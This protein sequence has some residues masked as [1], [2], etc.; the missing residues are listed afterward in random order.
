MAERKLWPALTVRATLDTAA[1]VADLVSALIDDHSPTAIQELTEH[2]LPA[3]GL[4]DPTS[5]PPIE[6]SERS[7]EWRIFFASAADRD[8]AAAALRAAPFALDVISD[9]VP[10]D[11]WAARSQQEISAVRA[12]PFI[13]APPWDVPSQLT[14]GSTLIIIEP[15]R[16]FGTGHHA[17]T[18]LCLRALGDIDVRGAHVLD[19]G[20]GSGVLAIAASLRGA[21]AV[22]AID[23]DADAIEAA[24]QSAT[25]NPAIENVKWLVGDFR[26]RSSPLIGPWDVV[27]ANLTGG[28][29]RSSADRLRALSTSG[30]LIASGFDEHERPDVEHALHMA[31]RA[32]Y[33]EDG[34]MGLSLTRP[35]AADSW[36]DARSTPR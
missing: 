12:G 26:E 8:R 9:D 13:V 20:T 7:L 19:L 24:Q 14:A 4:W 30:V 32:A 6:T 1:P 33:C 2:P 36:R 34:W 11:D 22:T 29:L 35:G 27:L 17:S 25:L 16:G 5:P 28:M 3:G 21:Q 10:D 18:R 15:S 31:V 23:V